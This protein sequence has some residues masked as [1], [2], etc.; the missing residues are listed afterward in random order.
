M[1]FS[2]ILPIFNVE[3]YLIECVESI[4]SQSFSNYEIILVDDGSTDNSSQICDD[5]ASRYS[6]IRA[7]HKKNGGLSDARNFGTKEARGEYIIYI[8]SDDFVLSKDFLSEINKSIS[9]NPDLIFYKYVKYFDDKKELGE[10]TFSYEGVDEQKS[11]PAQL[12]KLVE[13][14]SFYGMAWIKAIKKD[15]LIQNNI[16]FEVGLLGEDMEWNYHI[17]TNCNKIVFIDRPFIAYRQRSGSITSTHKIKNLTDFIYIIKKWSSIINSDIKNI[18]LKDALF[19]SL[20]KYYSNLLIVY[21]RL[22]DKNKRKYKKEIKNLSWILNYSL[23]SRPRTV[24]KFY[25]LFGFNF[26]ILLI[27]LRDKQ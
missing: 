2:I 21:A 9:S 10:C 13:L 26:T 6:F 20:A 16:F 27:K 24:H 17:I 12:H 23:S 25:R 18:E 4:L 1:K 8:D 22:R 3:K 5:Y 19:G 15:L 11:L 7:L 14:D